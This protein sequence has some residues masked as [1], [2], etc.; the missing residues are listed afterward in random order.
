MTVDK[1]EENIRHNGQGNIDT[2]AYWLSSFGGRGAGGNGF[3]VGVGS[4]VRGGCVGGGSLDI[5]QAIQM[6]QSSL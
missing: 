1:Q 4:G 2:F 3:G 5:L 6:D